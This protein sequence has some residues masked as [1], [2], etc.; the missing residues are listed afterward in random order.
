V[1]FCD[2]AFSSVIFLSLKALCQ[3]CSL[4]HWQSWVILRILHGPKECS[5][6]C[7]KGFRVAVI[8]LVS[9]VR[10][11]GAFSLSPTYFHQHRFDHSKTTHKELKDHNTASGD[12]VT[13][14]RDSGSD[15][16][17]RGARETTCKARQGTNNTLRGATSVF[18]KEQRK[19]RTATELRAL[20]QREKADARRPCAVVL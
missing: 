2:G 16:C 11:D 3:S 7:M 6:G 12:Q 20:E 15:R 10:V 14:F 17:R 4:P 8:G 18:R 19:D 13:F 1:Q 9:F 5:R